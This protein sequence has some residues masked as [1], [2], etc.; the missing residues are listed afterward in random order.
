MRFA[1]AVLATTILPAASALAQAP[2]QQVGHLGV[3]P[4]GEGRVRP[5]AGGP[6]SLAVAV[7]GA[8]APADLAQDAEDTSARL[9]PSLP[10]GRVYTD[11]L[12]PDE[13]L[14]DTSLAEVAE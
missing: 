6:E 5:A 7:E 9:S 11:D 4:R 12:A 10:G 8:A 3:V 2:G 14:V 1:L 13:W